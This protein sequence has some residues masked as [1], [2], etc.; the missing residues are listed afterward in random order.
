MKL[1]TDCKRRDLKRGCRDL[2]PPWISTLLQLST[3][4]QS[5]AGVC[6]CMRAFGRVCWWVRAVGHHV[7]AVL[8][9]GSWRFG[10]SFAA[11]T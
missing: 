8:D 7:G 11:L 9:F 10:R 1:A 5:A 4:V 2:V 6:A 3:L